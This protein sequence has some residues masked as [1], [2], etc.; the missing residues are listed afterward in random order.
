MTRPRRLSGLLVVA[1]I[2]LLASA[3]P[4]AASNARATEEYWPT[5]DW[6]TSGPEE[7]QLN[8]KIIKKLVKRIRRNEVRDI[9][10]LLII[11][12]GYLVTEAYFHGWGPD[13]LHTLQS[14]SKSVTS[15][16]VGAA[17]EQGR[18]P[19]VNAK[20]MDYFSDYRPIRNL[21]ARKSAIRLEDLLTMRTGMD[22]SEGYYQ[23]SPLQ[24]MNECQCDWLRFV[25]DWPMRETP[26][27]RFEYNSGGVIMLGGVVQDAAGMRVE[28]FAEQHLFEPLG[29]RNS[30]WFPGL[31]N[32]VVHT[33][34][35]L[36]LRPRDMAKLGY[37][38]LRNG[39]WGG[40]QIVSQEWIRESVSRKVKTDWR[41]ASY[42]VDYGYLWWVLSLDGTGAD[43]SPDNDIYTASGAQGQWIFIIPKHD[44][45]VVVTASSQDFSSPV[46]FLYSDIL[47]AVR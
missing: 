28:E 9:D 24:R 2:S 10:S 7:Q 14:V 15:L 40:R 34:G 16:V 18:I 1:A 30:Y 46:A 20:A 35:G 29:I 8:K 12:N 17:I 45:V 42:P 21:D 31:G 47:R 3:R 23:G 4:D 41:F 25:V 33:G 36:N 27:D 13:R 43:Q 39:R 32:Q 11:R 37:L 22:W 6:R 19:D 5:T 38:V 26:G 44:M